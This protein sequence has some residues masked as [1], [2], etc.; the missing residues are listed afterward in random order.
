MP[1]RSICADVLRNRWNVHNFTE[2]VGLQVYALSVAYIEAGSTKLNNFQNR[3]QNRGLTFHF[4]SNN[5][6]RWA[7]EKPVRY[8]YKVWEAL[9]NNVSPIE[10]IES[11]PASCFECCVTSDVWDQV[12]NKHTHTHAHTH[13]HTHTHTHAHAHT[14]THTHT[15]KHKHTHMD[16][17]DKLRDREKHRYEGS[18]HN[19][20]LLS[21]SLQ[22]RTEFCSNSL[23]RCE[24]SKLQ[25]PVFEQSI[26][27]VSR[28]FH[29]NFP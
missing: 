29:L 5:N 9:L 6:S 14:H 2:I 21:Y 11:P 12:N 1:A 20:R 17:I 16:S 24:T 8:S 22:Y 3:D 7:C 10:P 28:I 4:L 23:Q 25:L 15:H 27:A 13:T 19:T 18:S 26:F